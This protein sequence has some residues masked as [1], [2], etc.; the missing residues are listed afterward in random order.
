MRRRLKQ[1]AEFGLTILGA[2]RLGRALRKHQ[3]LVLAYHNIV[4]DGED[5]AR[6]DAS[7]HLSQRAFARQLDLLQRTH[8]IVSLRDLTRARP[9]KKPR[10]VITFDDAYAGALEAGVAELANRG[11]PATVFVTPAFVGGATFWWDRYA[12]ADGGG[13]DSQTREHALHTLEGKEAVITGWARISG[14]AEASVPAHQRGA[15]EASLRKAAASGL[16]TFGSHTWS[17]PNLARLSTSEIESELTRPMEWLNERFSNTLPFLAYPY[18][19]FSQDTIVVAR[20]CGYAG[21]FRIAGGW[22]TDPNVAMS[23]YE[24]PRWNVPAGIS[25]RGFQLRAGGI[26]T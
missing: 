8:D 12:R 18:G 19:L 14:L 23:P 22:L 11:L 20:R 13:L 5:G 3:T 10:A 1:A 26:M 7:L 25:D 16:I 21:A 6:G 2:T 24:L 4:P 9:G 15:S 17:H